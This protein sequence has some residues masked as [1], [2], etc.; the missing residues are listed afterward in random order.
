MRVVLDGR[1]SFVPVSEPFGGTVGETVA[2]GEGWFVAEAIAADGRPALVLQEHAAADLLRPSEDELYG[3]SVLLFDSPQARVS[4]T[5][6]QGWTTPTARS[7]RM[8]LG[9]LAATRGEVF[10]Q[11]E[12]LCTISLAWILSRCDEAS[13]AFG[14]LIGADRSLAWLAEDLFA[15]VPGRPDLVGRVSPECSPTVIVEAKLGA[16][17]DQ[18]QLLDYH[19]KGCGL[20]LLVPEARVA[21]T[22]RSIKEWK[23]NVR[24]VSWDHALAAIGAAAVSQPACAADLAQLVDLYRHVER[25]WVPSFSA[26]ELEHPAARVEDL[27][28]L[29]D[30]VSAHLH[31]S[32]LRARGIAWKML[33]M[34]RSRYRYVSMQ[35]GVETATHVAVGVFDEVGL[36]LAIRWHSTTGGFGEAADRLEMSGVA[37]Q[38]HGGH[39]YVP[40]EVPPDAAHHDMVDALITQAYGV[41]DV[42][43]PSLRPLALTADD[44]RPFI[45]DVRWQFAKTMPQWPHEYTVREWRPDVEQEFFDF[46]ALI[47]RDGI[48][49]PWPRDAAS[50]RY[51]HTYLE[52][53][54]WEYWSMGEPIPETVLINRARLGRPEVTGEAGPTFLG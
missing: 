16:P 51:H 36:P 26:I 38:R 33:P 19:R 20:V 25:T 3:M 46:V 35:P 9:H 1:E 28:K 47:R 18:R 17:L 54:G 43:E 6:E 41:I 44:A 45:A 48:V 49:K 40:L 21:S 52:L 14:E 15:G 10:T 12:V 7:P 34:Q 23:L 37:L 5:A 11:A 13:R 42:A 53:D 30:Q 31:L 8:L 22:C 39:V 50:P 2:A 24:V 32:I 4:F 29:A 27:V